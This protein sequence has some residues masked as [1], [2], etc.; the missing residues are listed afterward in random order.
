[1]VCDHKYKVDNKSAICSYIV[2][3]SIWQH[4]YV[5]MYPNRYK[6]IYN[7]L[8]YIGS[9]LVILAILAERVNTNILMVKVAYFL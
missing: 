4:L 3:Y 7:L 5:R 9:D 1:M 6:Y 8:Q 2:V